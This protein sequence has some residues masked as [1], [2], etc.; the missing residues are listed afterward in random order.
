MRS[1]GLGLKWLKL[2]GQILKYGTFKQRVRD[3]AVFSV[4]MQLILQPCA[5]KSVFR[6][7]SNS[8][9]A[10]YIFVIF[11]LA[12]T[13]PVSSE[14]ECLPR[15]QLQFFCHH[16]LIGFVTIGYFQSISR[17]KN[18]SSSYCPSNYCICTFFVQLWKGHPNRRLCYFL[19]HVS[20]QN[21]V[22]VLKR[23]E[24]LKQLTSLL[25]EC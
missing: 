3:F 20:S 7:L 8:K 4:S 2:H 16:R 1:A 23:A 9:F 14:E 18:P 6:S 10:T 11:V 12:S 15:T 21:L 24:P 19:M 13:E 5:K 22:F 25:P 17:L